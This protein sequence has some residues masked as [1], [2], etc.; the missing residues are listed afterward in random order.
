M[1]IPS[2]SEPTERAERPRRTRDNRARDTAQ[3]Q[4]FTAHGVPMTYT[5]KRIS[6]HST[7]P[8]SYSPTRREAVAGLMADHDAAR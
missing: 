6:S 3:V 7:F 4:P 8:R 2:E 1:T 5:D